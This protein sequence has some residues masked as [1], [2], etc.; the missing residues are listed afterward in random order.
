M[1][2]IRDLAEGDEADVGGTVIRFPWVKH[3][4]ELPGLDGRLRPQ[5]AEDGRRGGRRLHPPARRPL[6]HRVHGQGGQG[7]GRRRRRTRPGRRSPSASPPPPTS[8]R[9]TRPRRS[10][11]PASSAAGSAA[12]SATTSPTWSPGTASTPPPYPDEL[13]DVHQGPRGLRLRPPRPRRQPR[14][15]LRP[16]RDRRPVL[17]D[18]P[19]R[20]AHREAERA[21]RAGRRPVRRVRHARRPGSRPSTPTGRRSSRP[22]T[23]ERHPQRSERLAQSPHSSSPLPSVPGRGPDDPRTAF[24]ASA[25]RLIGLPMTDTAPTAISPSA[26]VTLP[27]G[28]VELAPGA[29][30]ERLLRQRG[31]AARPGR[32]SAPG[33]RTTSPRCGSAWPTTSPPGPWP[34]VWSPLGMDWKQAVLHHRPGQRDRAGPDAAHRARRDRSTASPSRSSPAPPSGCA[35]PTCPRSYGRWSPAAGSA[36]RPGSAAQAHLLPRR[37]SSSADGWATPGTSAATP[38]TLWLSLRDLLGAR[39]R[40]HLPGH[41][42]AP[43]LRELG[44]ALRAGRRGRAADLDGGKAGGFG[45]LLDQPSKLGWGSDFWKLFFPSLMGM[46]G[47]WSTLSL[48]IPDF[49]RFGKPASGPRSGASPL[50]LPTTMTAF[51]L[52]SVLVT[53]G[54]Q[55][56]YGDADLGPGSSSPPRPTTPSACCSPWSPCW[57]RPS[58]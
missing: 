35:A 42:D 21:A 24:P 22:S 55:A 54:S 29:R 34:P 30:P 11:T 46:I 5:G 14:H 2:V 6:P 10:P 58:P 43:P 49:T 44:G 57:S 39:S 52:L 12:W 36:S 9:T 23:A 3:G 50:G 8:P 20:D 38:W 13:T 53:S 32:T 31:P 28:R 41:G 19:G 18:R 27:D 1:K 16:G 51:A 4:A 33:P 7:R 37:A 40:H 15:R 56:V 26:Q 47:F 48:N 17:P 25:P 45:P